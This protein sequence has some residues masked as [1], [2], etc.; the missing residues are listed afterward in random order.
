[1]YVSSSLD[2]SYWWLTEGR[3]LFPKVRN[4]RP[5]GDWKLDEV[6]VAARLKVPV[7]QSLVEEVS[8]TD[9]S[10]RDVPIPLWIS[11]L[12]LILT[13]TTI[14][15]FCGGILPQ[16]RLDP[17]EWTKCRDRKVPP[18][19]RQMLITLTEDFHLL[20]KVHGRP[21]KN[22]FYCGLFAV[23]K[24][25]DL[26]RVI[27]DTRELNGFVR[28]P[29]QFQMASVE[30][31]FVTVLLNIYFAVFDIRHE[32]FQIPLPEIAKNLFLFDCE[33]E[34]FR[35]RVWPMGFSHSPYIATCLCATLLVLAIRRAGF[36]PEESNLDGTA[37]AKVIIFYN[38]N[39][40]EMGRVLVYLDNVMIATRAQRTREAILLELFRES[41][42]IKTQ[43]IFP[44]SGVVVKGSKWDP[45][46]IQK[47]NAQ[48][49]PEHIPGV[50]IS[51]GETEYLNVMWKKDPADH[52]TVFWKHSATERWECF[53]NVPLFESFRFWASLT[54]VLLWD[55][56]IGGDDKGSV[57]EVLELCHAVGGVDDYDL[58]FSISDTTR[59][60]IQPLVD[61]MLRDEWRSR[62]IDIVPKKVIFIASDAM[63]V[64][65]A[66]V[67]WNHAGSQAKIVYKKAWSAEEKSEPINIRE[68]KAAIGTIYEAAKTITHGTRAMLI[69]GT[70]NVTARAALRHSLYPG[71]RLLTQEL[72]QLKNDLKVNHCGSLLKAIFVPGKFQ[73]AD[74][75]SR[76]EPLDEDICR[77]C[78]ALLHEAYNGMI[79][80]G[81]ALNYLK[82]SR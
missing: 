34:I 23:P 25:N 6:K 58:V 50:T 52:L 66:G 74:A 40:D 54:G 9:R 28:P 57:A 18:E 55:W 77:K 41:N 64:R 49:G 22:A 8:W 21:V 3:H 72:Q 42:E 67:L 48:K 36:F 81:K 78:F 12:L 30:D 4:M 79:S 20:E 19:R 46:Y 32:F 17:E 45:D 5:K 26:W 39:G 16:W 2:P 15:A 53:R 63:G 70:D 56:Q 62:R 73:A 59:R 60:E 76:K 7:L 82:R 38:K 27:F 29:T 75:P 1:M 47:T 68:T 11:G 35:S 69:I 71:N 37:P 13:A 61:T 31:V 33:G 10:G 24:T 14:E 44:R 51:E 80:D 65:G 43:G